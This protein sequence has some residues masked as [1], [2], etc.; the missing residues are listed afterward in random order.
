VELLKYEE[1]MA[2]EFCDCGG[3]VI[4]NQCN[5]GCIKGEER[6]LMDNKEGKIEKNMIEVSGMPIEI[7]EVTLGSNQL[8]ECQ[9]KLGLILI[10]KELSKELKEDTLIHEVIHMIS[11]ANALELDE[12]TVAVL[13]VNL[14]QYLREKR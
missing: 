2:Y 3:L 9:F 14:S 5:Q 4:G 13:A 1:G 10:D 8:G 6:E 11:A 7:K 12:T